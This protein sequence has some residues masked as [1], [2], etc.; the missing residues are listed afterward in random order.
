MCNTRQH[1]NGSLYARVRQGG[2]VNT[3]ARGNT[4]TLVEQY[5]RKRYI[6]RRRLKH[7]R[8]NSRRYGKW[9]GSG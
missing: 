6:R 2:Q 3:T 9:A 1:T 8:R 5:K 4:C 7:I